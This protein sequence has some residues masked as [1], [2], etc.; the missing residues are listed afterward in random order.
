MET[1]CNL[2]TSRFST[3]SHICTPFLE[4]Y[5]HS[6]WCTSPGT[7]YEHF[8]PLERPVRMCPRVP[9]IALYLKRWKHTLHRPRR[10]SKNTFD[11]LY[12]P[13]SNKPSKLYLFEM[14]QIE[15]TIRSSIK[16]S[17]LPSWY[18]YFFFP[19]FHWLMLLRKKKTAESIISF[20]KCFNYDYVSNCQ[21][22][23]LVD[24]HPGDKVYYSYTLYI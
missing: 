15:T 11:Q 3:L 13:T 8:S 2:I 1:F 5:F 4:H 6:I 24:G 16:R 17:S 10:S 21:C 9:T 14:H 12:H 20:L 18:D 22:L 7:I 23:T 19:K